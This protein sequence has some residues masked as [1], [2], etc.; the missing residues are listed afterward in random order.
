MLTSSVSHNAAQAT[1]YFDEG[2]SKQDY[3]SE[4]GEVKGKWHGLAAQKLG[5]KGEVSRDDFAA[6]ANN[7]IPGTITE[8]NPDGERLTPRDAANRKVG[9]DFTFSVPKSVSIQYALAKDER[10][11]KAVEQSV[12]ETMKEMEKSNGY[13]GKR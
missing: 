3:Y 4:K 11:L 13:P 12:A 2:L 1:K 10:I 8:N 9:Y 5:L 6:L 7:R